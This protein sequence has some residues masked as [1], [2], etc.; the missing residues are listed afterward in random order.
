[1]AKKTDK[2]KIVGLVSEETGHRHYYTMKNT[3]NTPDKL[4]LRKYDPILRR[5]V[6]YSET[7]KSLGRNEVKPKK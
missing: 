1:M 4:R 5:H 7:K 6:W 2:R 3:M